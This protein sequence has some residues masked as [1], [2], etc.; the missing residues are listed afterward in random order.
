[1]AGFDHFTH[2]APYYDRAIP[3]KALETLLMHGGFT[4]DE[5]VLDA[6]GGTGRVASTIRPFVREVVVA[7]LSKGM[8]RQALRKGLATILTPVEFLPIRSGIF[9]RILMI[10]ALHHVNNQVET[11]QEL[12]RTLKPGGMIIIEEPD[13][14]RFPVKIVA[15]AERIALMRSHFLP[16][17]EIAD[18]FRKFS[19]RVTIYYEGFNTWVIV[20]K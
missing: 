1:M 3:F 14:R 10:D 2:F 13:V 4:G 6:G 19:S 20:R 17:A 7:D 11:A 16:P 15:L 8:L 5:I 18:L 9:D 12:W